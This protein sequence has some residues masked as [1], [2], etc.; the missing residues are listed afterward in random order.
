M[1]KA[2]E[3][4][5]LNKFRLNYVNFP[6][7]KIEPTESPDFIIYGSK[8]IGIEVTQ[9]F[10]DQD[11]PKGSKLRRMESYQRKLLVDIVEV[12]REREFPICLVD[13]SLNSKKFA[14]TLR[15]KTVAMKCADEIAKQI[16]FKKEFEHRPI[17]INNY[18]QLPDLVLDIGIWFSST[19]TDFEYVE[20]SGGIGMT[21]TNEKLQ[22]VLDKKEKLLKNYKECDE[23]WLVIKEGSSSADYFPKID[24]DNSYIRTSFQKVFLIRQFGSKVISL[25]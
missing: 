2:E 9:I 3:Q 25:V 20:S 13:I 16:S 15:P 18:G 7:G 8:K 11:S 22:F 1:D 14:V 4:A 12:L 10:Q 23:Y 5:L 6:K 19:L 24:I 21:L 17:T